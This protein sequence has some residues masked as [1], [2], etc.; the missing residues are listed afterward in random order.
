M[1]NLNNKNNSLSNLYYRRF[2]YI[3]KDYI[4]KSIKNL[5]KIL[6]FNFNL[7]LYNYDNYYYL[8]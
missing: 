7:I 6:I 8:Y 4:I 3:N 5:I 1:L 2:L